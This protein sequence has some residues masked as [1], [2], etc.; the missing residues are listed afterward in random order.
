MSELVIHRAL[1]TPEIAKKLLSRNVSNRKINPMRVLL[2]ARQMKDNKWMEDIGDNIRFDTNGVLIDGQH[3]LLALIKSNTSYHFTI[4]EGI[5]PD[6]MNVIDTGKNRNAI[7]VFCIEKVKY[8]NRV[9]SILAKYNLLKA[10]RKDQV[11]NVKNT[12]AEYLA[13]YKKDPERW[14]DVAQKVNK[15]YTLIGR[16]IDRSLI[17]GCYAYFQD[18]DKQLAFDFINQVC[19]GQNVTN[20]VVFFLRNVLSKDSTSIRKMKATM[21]A[22][23][24]IKAFNYFAEGK[25]PISLRYNPE[26]EQFPTLTTKRIIK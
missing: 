15:W 21:K 6:A 18:Y 3:R 2:Y 25:T 8:Y 22:A 10:G 11:M 12:N 26:R 17:G 24:M 16:I 1:I 20:S 19:T 13:Q 4:V 23:Y 14:D 5:K 9:P 7:D